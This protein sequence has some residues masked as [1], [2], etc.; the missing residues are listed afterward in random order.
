MRRLDRQTPVAERLLLTLYW[1]VSGYGLRGSRAITSLLIVVLSSGIGFF[2]W[3]FKAEK[4]FL[5]SLIYSA[6]STTSL[7]RP[8]ETALTTAGQLLEI[9]LRLLGPLLFGLLLLS[10]RGRVKR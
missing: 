9:G 3:G 4:T 7:L 2:L 10:L 8:P 1:L 5:R 6:N